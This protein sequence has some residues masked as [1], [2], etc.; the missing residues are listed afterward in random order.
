MFSFGFQKAFQRGFQ[1][2]DE[3]FFTRVRVLFDHVVS[4]EMNAVPASFL[5]FGKRQESGHHS[6]GFFG[7]DWLHTFRSRRCVYTHLSLPRPSR[8]TAYPGYF[9]FVAFA[10]A[11][12]LKVNYWASYLHV[13]SAAF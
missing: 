8:N 3:V 1:A 5:E 4:A 13:A 11:F 9:V 12:M 2:D 6:R 7:T 10:S